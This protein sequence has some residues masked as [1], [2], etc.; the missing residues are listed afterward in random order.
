MDASKIDA[1]K[2]KLFE[3]PGADIPGALARGTV[4]AGV[5]VEPVLTAALASGDIVPFAK[6]F[7]AIAKRFYISS[8]FAPHDWLAAN[9]TL[10]PKL[11][12]AIYDAARWANANPA[13]SA[14]IL[15]KASKLDPARIAAMTRVAMA[16]SLDAS[17]LQPVLD[18][19]AEYK[20]IPTPVQAKTLI[21]S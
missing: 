5:V 20:L 10:V 21:A 19:A 7:D 16:T 18:A 9:A 6:P 15:A 12:D 11:R 4:S 14:P 3:M 1:D 17:L 13:L 8:W 2:V